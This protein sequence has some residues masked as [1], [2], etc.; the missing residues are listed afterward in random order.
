M[1]LPAPGGGQQDCPWQWA[2]DESCDFSLMFMAWWE[3]LLVE[4][5][6]CGRGHGIIQSCSQQPVNL[7][8][9]KFKLCWV[10]TIEGRCTGKACWKSLIINS[11][12]NKSSILFYQGWVAKGRPAEWDSL[13][14][15]CL[16][17]NMSWKC[18]CLCNLFVL[19]SITEK[20]W[21]LMLTDCLN[22]YVLF[23]KF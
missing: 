10:I 15:C 3:A 14:P 6:P 17:I 9:L 1:P 20:I 23:E 19:S 16:S 13:I 4:L 8:S 18:P 12:T 2:K 11:L 22:M 21:Y 7:S 5:N